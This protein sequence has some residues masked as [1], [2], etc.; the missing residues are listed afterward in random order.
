MMTM[1]MMMMITMVVMMMMMTKRRCCV[2]S[3]FYIS[4]GKSPTGSN[5]LKNVRVLFGI[6]TVN[7]STGATSSMWGRIVT[8]V[9]I[10]MV[11][12]MGLLQ[13]QSLLC[14]DQILDLVYTWLPFCKDRYKELPRV[15]FIFFVPFWSNFAFSKNSRHSIF[16]LICND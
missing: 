9:M 2:V 8:L 4:Q 7:S 15:S 11:T 3:S 12:I 10:S 16:F 1:M 6:C 14:E 13:V 5:R